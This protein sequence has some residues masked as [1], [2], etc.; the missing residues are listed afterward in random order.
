MLR[1]IPN[2]AHP[3][4]VR[5]QQHSPKLHHAHSTFITTAFV[6]L[7][8]PPLLTSL[9][10]FSLCKC[11]I[12]GSFSSHVFPLPMAAAVRCGSWEY[13]VNYTRM[14]EV[15]ALGPLCEGD[16][17][18]QTQ[19]TKPTHSSPCCLCSNRPD[20]PTGIKDRACCSHDQS[21]Q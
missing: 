18:P 19:G 8:P 3:A 10:T 1:A 13:T 4:H 9:L 15:R 16:S 5:L 21:V 14:D 6:N 7:L 17:A 20:A 11:C 2:L 12:I